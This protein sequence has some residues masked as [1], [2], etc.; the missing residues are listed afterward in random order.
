[1][2]STNGSNPRNGAVYNGSFV[3]PKDASILLAI[4]YY[5]PLDLY[6][7]DL[8]AVIPAFKDP[9]ANSGGKAPEPEIV[10]DNTKSLKLKK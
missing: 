3:V 6:G 7:E 10:I 5:K 2:Y 1:M 8:K 9:S 4:A